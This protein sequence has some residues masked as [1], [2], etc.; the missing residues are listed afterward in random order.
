MPDVTGFVESGIVDPFKAIPFITYAIHFVASG[1]VFGREAF[2]S[3]IKTIDVMLDVITFVSNAI[4]F[5]VNVIAF[6]PI[7]EV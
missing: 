7:Q 5:A 4:T 6:V 2:D 3:A 1:V